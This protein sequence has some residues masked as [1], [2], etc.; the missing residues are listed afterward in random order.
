[1]GAAMSPRKTSRALVRMSCDIESLSA[2]KP[3][4]NRSRARRSSNVCLLDYRFRRARMATKEERAEE[5]L[6]KIRGLEIKT[7]ALVE[8]AVAADYHRKFEERGKT[9]EDVS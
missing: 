2:T 6:R 1:M 4:R 8:T 9:F 5:I 7:R 3:K